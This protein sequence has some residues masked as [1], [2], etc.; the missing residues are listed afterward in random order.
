[1][2]RNALIL[3]I[4]LF[5]I[6]NCSGLVCSNTVKAEEIN[7][8]TQIRITQNP[9]KMTY[10]SGENFDTTGMVVEGVYADGTSS[11]IT[12]YEI[13]D[14]N[15]NQVGLQNVTIRYQNCTTTLSVMVNPGKV[16]GIKSTY[17]DTTTI[18]LAWNSIANVTSYEI[19]SKDATT[20]NYNLETTV[21]TNKATFH[22][23]PATI[24]SYQ[25]RA[26]V[27]ISGTK[28]LGEFSNPYQT[29]TNPEQVMNLKVVN[30]T[31]NSIELSWDMVSGATGYNI[32][33]YNSSTKKYNKIASSLNT[34][35]VDKK[36]SSGKGYTYRIKAYILNKSYQGIY[37]DKVQLSTNPDMVVLKGKAGDKKI[38]LT[39]AKVTG[40][41]S[42][43]IYMDDGVSGY[44]LLTTNTGNSNCKYIAEGLVTGNTYSF[45][46]IAHRKY[47][48]VTYDSEQSNT[49]SVDV[50]EVQATNTDA[51]YFPTVDDFIS[52]DAYKIPFFRKNVVYSKSF[53]IPGLINTKSG[54]FSCSSM[55]PQ[56]ITFA[57]D[58]LLITC[59]DRSFQENSVIY[60]LDKNTK[61]LLTTFTVPGKSHLGGITYDGTNVWITLH[62]G[63]AAIPF[64]QMESKIKEGITDADI[65]ISTTINLDIIASYIT[66]YNDKLWIGTYDELKETDMNSYSILNKDTIPELELDSTYTV[67]T[68]VQGI[69]FNSSGD[70][71][72]S[73]SCQ[74]YKGLRGYMRQLDIYKPEVSEEN[75]IISLGECINTVEMP[76]MNEGVAIDGDYLY[77]IYESGSFDNASYKMDRVCAFEL[78]SLNPSKAKKK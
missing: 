68:R 7:T 60:A 8:V 67:P 77:V 16:T 52:S 49:I 13:V 58:Y 43:D 50:V 40:V 34:T 72:L 39:W 27:D 20:G 29:A 24:H 73:R 2:K 69:V 55:C 62:K 22:Y 10:L 76:S 45:Y 28:Y 25:I 63:V 6:I 31:T 3:L 23:T 70:L 59:Y 56:S 51:K 65:E 61:E 36:V 18:T 17:H 37:S 75:E 33:R 66:Y 38:R 78:S 44:T 26:I 53:I 21:N 12:D 47:N 1:M 11:Y 48:G 9:T 35:Y 19:Y 57:G 15:S 5:L 30:S 54:G 4:L 42:Y 74:L 32:Y 64:S 14:F 71:I 41:T 46:A